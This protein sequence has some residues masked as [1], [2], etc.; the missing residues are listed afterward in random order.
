MD[1]LD[2]Q[3]I[4]QLRANARLPAVT[5]AKRLGV[6]RSTVQARIDRLESDGTIA[7]YTVRLGGAAKPV[8]IRATVLLAVEP[9]LTPQILGRLKALPDVTSAHTASGRFDLILH[10]SAKSPEALDATLDAIG[11]MPGVR[12]SE[13]LI[14]LSTNI[15]RD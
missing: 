15:A 4:E 10:L 1:D 11:A 14:H 6:A 8:R 13:S 3:I 12:S 9:R 7:G 2:W 5:L